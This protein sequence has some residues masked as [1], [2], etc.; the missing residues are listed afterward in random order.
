MAQ[1]DHVVVLMLENR[2]FDSL[3]GRL[4][5]DR[6]DFDGLKGDE[7]NV[8]NEKTYQVWASGSDGALDTHIPTPDPAELFTDMSEQIFGP[9][10]GDGKT[11]TMSGF[12]ANYAKV[13]GSDPA[14]VMHYYTPEQVPV[15][16]TLARSFG[17]S[18]RWHASAPNQTWPNRFFAHCGTARGYVNNMPLHVPYVMHTVFNRL[19]DKQRSWRIYFHDIPQSGTLARIWSELPEH[20]YL[21]EDHFMADAMAGRLP[22]Y[23]FIEPRYFACPAVNRPP[24]DEHPPH[25]VML[26]ERLIAR[27]YDALRN[28]PGWDRTL[29]II[30]YDEHG[31]LYDH[32]PPPAAVSP[33]NHFPDG[34]KFDRFGVRVPAVLVSPWIPAG[35][36][37]RPAGE[38]PFDH[39]SIIATL[40]QLFGIES[41]TNRDGA[42]PDVL[43]AL[44]LSEPSNAGP[45][46]LPLPALPPTPRAIID[47]ADLPP[48][49]MQIA[50][51][52][53]ANMLPAGSAKAADT[54]ALGEITAKVVSREAVQS[55]GDALATAE[56]G[57]GRFL[58]GPGAAA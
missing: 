2:S 20:L 31:G 24:N 12:A 16:S 3:L 9:G 36:V 26:G 54:L 34:F 39:T 7:S 40:R 56:R 27:C 47:A 55:V 25:D 33:D 18:D 44:S 38:T 5:Q 4:Y 30:T 37:I 32:V 48:N 45:T 51:A 28:G 42:A 19:T 58:R 57:L 41:L 49:S 50:L 11:A 10:G 21:F 17:V 35:S 15:I 52:Q 22:N 29:F 23:S 14:N 53:F 13:A 1:I 43:H 6:S 46:H 8:A